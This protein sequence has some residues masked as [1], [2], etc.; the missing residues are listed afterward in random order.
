MD[1][2]RFKPLVDKLFWI[3]FI[4]AI[5]LLVGV[6][7]PVFL[8][9]APLAIIITLLV[10]LIV[11]YLLVSPLFGFVELRESSLYIKYGFFLTREIPYSKIRGINKEKKLYA[12]SMLSLKNSVEHINIKYNTFDVTSV[13]VAGNDELIKAL[14]ERMSAE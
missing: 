3:T 13:S 10:D 14:T 2:K 8:Y 5:L 9:P 4:I 12:D 7:V 11:V 1:Y 6:T